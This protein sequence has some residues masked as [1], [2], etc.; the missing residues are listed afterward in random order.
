MKAKNFLTFTFFL[1][2]AMIFILTSC[3]KD[4]TT[5]KDTTNTESM[6]Q[7]TTDANNVENTSD[8]AMD[9]ANVVLSA[10]VL[11]SGEI[12]GGPCN[13][14]VTFSPVVNDS[15]T[16]D[17]YYHG[18]DCQERRDRQGHIIL[19]KKYHEPWGTP[20]ATVLATFNDFKVTRLS[21]GKSLTFNGTKHF[22]NVSG[23]YLW[24]LDSN[25]VTSIEHRVWGS[26][27]ATFDDG[28]TRVWNIA[29]QRVFTGHLGQLIMTVT[30]IGSADGY[31]NLW[32]WGTNRNGENFYTQINQAIVH[33]QVCDFDPCSGV[34]MHQIPSAS[35]SATA[36]FGYDSNNNP[37]TNGDCPTR[38]RVDWVSGS[39][40]G[41]FYLPL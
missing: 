30:G 15:I 14:T 26:I 19:K 8:Q 29:R 10:G 7:L 34:M 18:H 6:Q 17:I 39:H 20:G 27:T 25:T 16:I 41:T 38:Y 9:D 23:H 22:Q 1:A 5:T 36:T 11:K 35:K 12:G 32:A 21:N 3:A 40:S 13:V 4:K 33:K 2:A 24:E 28:K 31:D 37:I